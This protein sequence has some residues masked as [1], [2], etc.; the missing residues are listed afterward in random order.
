MEGILGV[1]Q[2][3]T[4]N[5][6]MVNAEASV[7]YCRRGIEMP[8]LANGMFWRNHQVRRIGPH[9]PLN[10]Q[11]HWKGKGSGGCTKLTVELLAPIRLLRGPTN[12]H[13]HLPYHT[14]P[15]ID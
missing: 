7:V 2:Q 14:T 15:H 4:P 10:R 6:R 8:S 13:S 1:R 9:N 3:Q 11:E 12:G 5:K